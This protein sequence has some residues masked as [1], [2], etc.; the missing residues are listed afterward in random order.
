[1]ASTSSS[2]TYTHP[3]SRSNQT[4]FDVFLS[5]RGE[6]TR[7]TFT[8][9]LYTAL[10]RAAIR[11]FR[12]NDE[13]RRG[14][15]LE[16]EIVKA[17]Q[18]SRASIVVLSQNYA[19]SRWCLEELSLIL[20]QKT[21][22]NHFVLPV[23]YHV[24]PSDVRNQLHSF[25]VEDT[26]WTEV[27]VKR[28]KLA[29][30]QVANLTGMVASGS[31]TKFI[32]NIVGTIKYE[33]DFKLV[34]TPAHLTGIE[35]RAKDINSW[36]RNEHSDTNIL[37]ICGMGGSGKTTLAQYIYNLNKHNFES[38]CFL[39]EIGKHSKETY[40]L[41]GLQKQLLTD[42]LG[43]KNIMISCV[44]EGAT[45]I[46]EALCMKK[47]L[48]VLDDVDEHGELEALLGTSPVHTQIK[49]IITTRLLDIR[50]W[51]ESIS[52]KCRVHVLKL[53]NDR[54]SL[55]VFSCHAFGSKLPLE[56]FSDL[57][58]ELAKY[59][60][61]NPLAL[62]VLGSSLFVS[63]EDTRERNNVIEIWRSRLN[64][65][66]SMKGDL[67]CN[68]QGV[69]QKSFDSLPLLSYKEL[70]LHIVVFFVGE[71][72]DYVVKILEHDWH[73]KAGIMTLINRCLLTISPNKKLM[74]HQLLQVMGRNIVREE[75][76]D[77]TKRTR[78][79]CSDEAYGLLTKG[80]RSETIEGLTLDT[81]KI[82]KGTKALTIKTGSLAKMHRLK[83]LQLKY[84]KLSGCYKNFPELRWLCWHGFHLKTIPS[85]LLMSNFLVAIDMTDGSLETFEAPMV[86]NSLK[87]LNLEGCYK[88]ISLRNLYLLP[89][90]ETLILW[91][92]KNLTH[93][94]KTI[95]GLESL[96]LLNLAGCKRFWTSLW[97]KK[98]V[99]PLFSFPRSL[100]FLFLDSCNLKNHN[101]LRV[102]FNDQ[103]FG[104]SLSRN[105]FE[106][107]PN[108]ID[109]KMLRVL[110]LDYCENLKS[111]LC[112]PSTLEELYTYD[113]KSLEKVTFQSGRFRLKK[114]DYRGCFKLSEVQGLFK[115]V[116]I[117]KLDEVDLG[118][119]IWVKA[120]QDHKVQLAGDRITK[121]RTWHIQML[122][123]YGIRSSYLQGIK[124]ESMMP[125]FEYTSEDNFLSFSVSSH[126]KKH[127]IKGLNVCCLYRL[128]GSMDKDRRC[129]FTK[130]INVT[131]GVTWIYNPIVYCK[132]RVDEDAT[133]LSYWPIGN[134]FDVGDEVEVTIFVEK[135][136]LVSK[137]GANLVYMDDGEVEQEENQENNMM[138]LEQVVGG[139]LSDFELTTGVY[140]LCRRDL[141]MSLSPDVIETLFG[142]TIPYTMLLGWRKS[143]QPC[144]SH[145]SCMEL[146]FVLELNRDT[147]YKKI[148]LGY[149]NCESDIPKI[150][151][152]VSR[153]VGV[154]CVHY[155][156]ERKKLF[157]MG[158]VDAMAVE[159]CVREFE[160]TV[161]I[162]Q[163]YYVVQRLLKRSGKKIVFWKYVRNM[164]DIFVWY[165]YSTKKETF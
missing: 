42:I 163:V 156:I 69:L 46:N 131:K 150:K 83:L 61:G 81:R 8:D 19:K 60:G 79:W 105:L 117:K 141:F 21:K 134:I 25:A 39:E 51:F 53:L 70:F 85:G 80:H 101:D 31:E 109:L 99:K 2:S 154:D 147:L 87:I 96:A 119:M 9:H 148:W 37:A 149:F 76:K 50:S 6:D 120:Y 100:K 34:S 93:V 97:Y 139:D 77:P 65:L 90:I 62:K 48:I 128:S 7:H 157:V 73:A 143:Y 152:A 115:L 103:L 124:V 54:E 158:D 24:D 161:K 18:S 16:P 113:C 82:K 94:C 146:N 130:I 10:N 116:A 15:H 12:D 159:T 98:H 160:K 13:I 28:W 91:D 104:M 126:S 49:I 47:V 164:T 38:S 111:I 153:L 20:E 44:S 106:L 32:D 121:G 144:D 123:E 136:M 1:M 118:H 92:C 14:Q 137:C 165:L 142:D 26:K 110:N 129:L 74:V 108:N 112:L 41:L 57:A 155:Y 40:G 162:V 132:P 17:I 140:Y 114:F 5:F 102:F 45:K 66:S 11:T 36:L 135:G 43:G 23:F 55:K 64:S 138:K 127:R 22:G 27:N 78:V 68:I 84:V 67:D 71:D 52:W 56:G 125:L 95:G 122:Y 107:M 72:E 89:N 133:W 33:L 59:C 75:S 29:L 58:V 3:S 86:L 35:T 151:K 4:R 145:D 30:T 88:L 63:A